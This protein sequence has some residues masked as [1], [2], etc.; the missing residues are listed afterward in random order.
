M[1]LKSYILIQDFR[2][3]IVRVTGVPHSPSRIETKLFRKGEIIQ[4]E[5]K[6]AN[7]QPAFVLVRGQL[8]VPLQVLKEVVSKD[9]NS[10]SNAEGQPETEKKDKEKYV[11]TNPKIKYLD[12]M[13]IGA[14]LGFGGVYLAERQGW[15]AVPEKKY[16]FYG[17]IAGALAGAYFVYRFKVN[18]PKLV[19]K[20]EE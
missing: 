19:K 10:S 7:N 5:M 1:A 15:I 4:G 13:L 9:I 17:A 12:A 8:V 18:K 6:H 2:S 20:E 16:R 11:Q 3:P 14:A